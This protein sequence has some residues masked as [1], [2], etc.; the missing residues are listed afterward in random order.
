MIRIPL[1][2]GFKVS[3]CHP[4]SAGLFR[5]H[6]KILRAVLKVER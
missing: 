1:C 2:L 5:A 6:T 3:L 4:D